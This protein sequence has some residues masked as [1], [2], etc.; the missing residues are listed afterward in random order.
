MSLLTFKAELSILR[1]PDKLRAFWFLGGAFEAIA[2]TVLR[3][4]SLTSKVEIQAQW[5]FLLHGCR[6]WMNHVLL[7]ISVVEAA[8][9]A[10]VCKTAYQVIELKFTVKVDIDH[11]GVSFPHFFIAQRS[12]SNNIIQSIMLRILAMSWNVFYDEVK[13]EAARMLFS[14]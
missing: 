4:V 6:H 9:V 5:S 14:R 1:L 8:D 12:Y 2:E 10:T 3:D 13:A 7:V 11:F